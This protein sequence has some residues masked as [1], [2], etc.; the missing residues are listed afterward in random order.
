[1]PQRRREQ[2]R[3]CT[4]CALFSTRRLR[5]SPLSLSVPGGIGSGE[6][7]LHAL[8]VVHPPSKIG[9]LRVLRGGDA[10]PRHD[11][12]LL[13]EEAT[14]LFARAPGKFAEGGTQRDR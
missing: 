5:L 2:A 8:G 6:R 14:A 7:Q 1:M 4:A 10:L 3:R 13:D 11:E 9:E 12:R